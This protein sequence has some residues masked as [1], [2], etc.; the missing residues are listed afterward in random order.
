V[1][2]KYR[3]GDEQHLEE[4]LEGVFLIGRP[5]GLTRRQCPRLKG[6]REEVV[7]GNYALVLEFETRN[8][9]TKEQWKERESKFGSFFGPGISAQVCDHSTR[10]LQGCSYKCCLCP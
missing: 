5:T 6:L 2:Q 3:Y 1:R 9:M 4:A 10:T 8:G 7:D